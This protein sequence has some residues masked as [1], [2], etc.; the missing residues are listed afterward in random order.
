MTIRVVVVDDQALV[1][2]GFG[3]VLDHEDDIEV[4]G[5]AGTGVEASQ[6]LGRDELRNEGVRHQH[7]ARRQRQQQAAHGLRRLGQV[8]LP[9]AAR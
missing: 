5:E 2:D 3:M 8:S 9:P 7:P 1:R 6:P 4:V